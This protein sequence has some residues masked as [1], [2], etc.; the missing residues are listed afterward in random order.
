MA[1]TQS[2]DFAM[3][4]PFLTSASSSSQCRRR[5]KSKAVKAKLILSQV[6]DRHV[7]RLHISPK[8]SRFGVIAK[9]FWI[10]AFLDVIWPGISKSDVKSWR[11]FDKARF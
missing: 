6:W 8:S 2:V 9:Y 3:A 5:Q 7:N 10:T 11:K 4:L 1:L